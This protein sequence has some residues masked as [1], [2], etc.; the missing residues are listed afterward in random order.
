MHGEEAVA[1]HARALVWDAHMDSLLRALVEGY[2]LGAAAP[3]HADL[4]RWRD[5][6]VN[7]QVLAL[8]V[9]T[10]YVPHHAAQRALQQADVLFS[11]IER[12]PE[13]VALA[14]SAADVRRI[15]GD[16]RLAALLALEGGV[17]IQHDLALLRTFHRLGV[18]SMTLTHSASTTWADASTDAPRW[19]GLND[20]GRAVVREMNRIGMVI[21]VSHVSD[22][23]VADVLATSRAPIIASHSCCRA[24][25]DHPRNLPDTLLRDIA[26][27]GG[28]VGINFYPGFLDDA[29]ARAL[30]GTPGDLLTLLNRPTAVAPEALGRVAAERHHAFF[31]SNDLPPVSIERVLDHIDHAVAVMGAEHVGIG[32]DFDGINASP[33]GLQSAADFPRLTAG[34]LARGHAPAD[35]EKILGGNFLR[36]LEA[37]QSLAG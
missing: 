31:A 35:V 3:G 34:M 27:I 12:Y 1:L 11:L 19:G 37:A 14:R 4:D 30:A 2:D 15:A 33:A 13:R 28:V 8:W 22:D 24:L 6:G 10:I 17:A 20:F 16:G 25:C 36:V 18:T 29:A 26:S 5:G 21:D 7:A 32:S 23:C 9:D